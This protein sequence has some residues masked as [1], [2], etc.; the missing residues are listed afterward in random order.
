MPLLLPILAAV[1]SIA[2]GAG[3]VTCIMKAVF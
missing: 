3:I 1:A 2:I